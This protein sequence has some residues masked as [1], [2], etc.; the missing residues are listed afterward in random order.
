MLLGPPNPK[1]MQ[2]A[3]QLLPVSWL[4][5]TPYKLAHPLHSSPITGPSSL[6]QDDPS[7]SCAS[8]LSLFVVLTYRVFSYHH[9]KGSHVPR[10]GLSYVFTNKDG[11]ER[12]KDFRGAWRSACKKSGL[13]HR[14][15]HDL[16]RTAVRNM[17]RAGVP[18]RVAMTISGHKT[19]SVFERYNIVDEKSNWQ[20]KA[21]THTSNRVWAQNRAQSPFSPKN[22]GKAR[23]ANPLILL[24]PR[25]GIEPARDN[26]PRDFKSLASTNSATQAR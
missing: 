15:F 1:S 2:E 19:R 21:S 12:I 14:L 4:A 24:V 10:K 5:V 17:V 11:D 18:E 25:A 7:P 26:V 22:K 3:K 13:G 8:I 20:Q 23:T 16:R 6:L 9:M